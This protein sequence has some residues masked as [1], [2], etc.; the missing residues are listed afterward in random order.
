MGETVFWKI[1][2]GIR[3]VVIFSLGVFIIID[4]LLEQEVEVPE[5]IIGMVMVGV[6]PI[7]NL[8]DPVRTRFRRRDAD[9]NGQ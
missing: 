9:D 4:A 8:W 1:F 2:D 6:L 5:L 7:E 3:R